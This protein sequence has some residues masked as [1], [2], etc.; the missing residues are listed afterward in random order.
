MNTCR[1]CVRCQCV[2]NHL[3]FL[4][5]LLRSH[6]CLLHVYLCKGK[7]ARRRGAAWLVRRERG[8]GLCR[9]AEIR[10]DLSAAILKGKVDSS[11]PVDVPAG[12]VCMSWS[13]PNFLAETVNRAKHV[14]QWDVL[15]NANSRAL[16]VKLSPTLGAARRPDARHGSGRLLQR[17]A[18]AT[19]SAEW[20]L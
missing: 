16:A 19:R 3:S 13:L 15:N 20:R 5:L 14:K 1:I 4:R 2:D 17:R 12:A 18:R 10:S 8:F 6:C 9:K 11:P 7:S